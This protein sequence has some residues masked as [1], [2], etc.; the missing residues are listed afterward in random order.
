MLAVGQ[1]GVAR[2]RLGRGGQRGAVED[3]RGFV[4][5]LLKQAPDGAVAF[6]HAFLARCV[7][8]LADAGHEGQWPVERANHVANA[9]LLGSAA[10]L[11]TPVWSFAAV[12][13]AAMLEGEQD[14]LQE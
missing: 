5:D 11:I 6:R 7:S 14:V 4:T 12:D 10:E 9:D 8:G 1:I 13:Q 2:R 3:S